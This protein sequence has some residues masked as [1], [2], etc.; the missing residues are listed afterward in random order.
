MAV[1]WQKKIE[2]LKRLI[3]AVGPLWP[4]STKLAG[5]A[6]RGPYHCEDCSFLRRG[7]DGKIFKDDK[8]GRCHHPV[9]IA[10]TEV[11]KDGSGV[12]IV[13]IR[14]G[15]CEFVDQEKD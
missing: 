11:K 2:C 10:D 7:S 6:E 14:H 15:C 8:G 1:S 4:K 12:P 3:A 13:N 5:Y 9:V